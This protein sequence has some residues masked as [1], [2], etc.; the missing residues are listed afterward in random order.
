MAAEKG[1]PRSEE[2][3][4]PGEGV[5]ELYIVAG[6][7]SGDLHGGNLVKALRRLRPELRVRAFGGPRLRAAGAELSADLMQLSIVGVEGIAHHLGTFFDL[8]DRFRRDLLERRPQVVILIDYPGLNFILAKVAR[9]LG[10]PVVY[11]CCPQL[12]AWAPWRVKKIRKLARLLL[13]IFPFEVPFFSGGPAEV[14]YV[15][16][17]LGDELVRFP[18]G[19]TRAEVRRELGVGEKELLVGL[20]PGSRRQEIAGLSAFMGRAALELRKRAPGL[21]FA[22]SCL[23]DRFR[24]LLPARGPWNV[25]GGPGERLMAASDLALV[26]S[27]TASLELAYFGV[28]SVVVYPVPKWQQRCFNLF[29]TTPFISTVNIL[30]RGE[31]IPERLV[32]GRKSELREVVEL[33]W[34]YV[35]DPG[36]R[37]AGSER[38]REVTSEVLAPGAS[39]KAAACIAAFC[40]RC[41]ADGSVE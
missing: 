31:L 32:S 2:K 24:S 38:L 28:P 5:L 6:E 14:V 18:A 15:G 4:R 9:R 27:G 40:D 34:P 19:E 23:E 8:L 21:K 33:L 41:R 26:A 11:Y 29:R 17:P 22:F 3:S 20:F 16:H 36:A 30:N 35:K 12:W 25:L 37:K 7:P 13:V 1:A 39:S 10:V